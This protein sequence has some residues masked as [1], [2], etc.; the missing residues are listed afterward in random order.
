M[1]AT[2]QQTY[3]RTLQDARRV[4]EAFQ[5]RTR[6]ID[7]KL[8][9]ERIA[10]LA[11]GELPEGPEGR[12]SGAYL[13][14]IMEVA[15]DAPDV[16][17][18]D[19]RAFAKEFVSRPAAYSRTKAGLAAIQ[20]EAWLIEHGGTLYTKFVETVLDSGDSKF[21]TIFEGLLSDQDK[22]KLRTG[23]G[24]FVKI[25]PIA[26]AGAINYDS[27]ELLEFSM[28]DCTAVGKIEKDVLPKSVNDPAQPG[29]PPETRPTFESLHPRTRDDY[30]RVFEQDGISRAVAAYVLGSARVH[31]AIVEGGQLVLTDRND[32]R[33]FSETGDTWLPD[34][35]S[36]EDH[37]PAEDVIEDDVD[38]SRP[39]LCECNARTGAMR[40]FCGT[41]S[42]F[43]SP[44]LTEGETRSATIVTAR[45]S[46][47]VLDRP[48]SEARAIVQE[49]SAHYPDSPAE[50][51]TYIEAALAEYAAEHG[52][53]CVNEDEVLR[54]AFDPERP[55][56]ADR[57]Y[58]VRVITTRRLSEALGQ[59]G[60]DAQALAQVATD[61]M[62]KRAPGKAHGAYFDNRFGQGGTLFVKFYNAPSDAGDV[63]KLNSKPNFTLSIGPFDTDGRALS[64]K[65]KAV[66]LTG[67]PRSL[68]W[69]GKTAP[70]DA[71]ARYIE[72]FIEKLDLDAPVVEADDDE[73]KSKEV[74]D[75][76]KGSTPPA[77]QD[78]EGDGEAPPEGDGQAVPFEPPEPTD[79]TDEPEYYRDDLQSYYDMQVVQGRS[80]PEALAALK[81]KFEITKPITI[82]PTGEVRVDGVT[83]NPKPPRPG[84]PPPPPPPGTVPPPGAEPEEEEP[85]SQIGSENSPPKEEES[86]DEARK[87]EARDLAIVA[88]I[89]VVL[90][91]LDRVQA[92]WAKLEDEVKTADDAEIATF[93]ALKKRLG[94]TNYLEVPDSDRAEV[95]ARRAAVD[96]L[97]AKRDAFW[98]QRADSLVA[99]FEVLQASASD[100]LYNGKYSTIYSA[101]SMPGHRVGEAQRRVDTDEI[102]KELRSLHLRPESR[103]YYDT[104]VRNRK[105]VE[106]GTLAPGA[107]IAVP[108]PPSGMDAGYYTITSKTP[109]GTQVKL[110]N[111]ETGEEIQ[112][113]AKITV[114][115]LSA[116]EA[117]RGMVIHKRH[118]DATKDE[119][120]EEGVIVV[121]FEMDHSLPLLEAIDRLAKLRERSAA[122]RSKLG[123]QHD[124]LE[125][126]TLH[127]RFHRLV[128]MRPSEIRQH[129]QSRALRETLNVTRKS[130]VESIQLGR[131]AVE[132]ALRLKGTPIEEWTP[133][134]WEW[135]ERIVKFIERTRRNAAPVVDEAGKPTRKVLTLRTWGHDPL[136][137]ARMSIEEFETLRSYDP[138]LAIRMIDATST[139]GP[140]ALVEGVAEKSA[141]PF[142]TLK[143][144]RKPLT[145]E[146]RSAC[147]RAKAVWLMDKPTPAVWRSEVD[148]KTYYVTNSPRLYNV[149]PTLEGAIGRFHQCIKSTN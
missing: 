16:N 79:R 114:L 25:E 97:R 81:K 80:E 27:G 21:L 4:A 51:D 48:L 73:E 40:S 100:P 53:A 146:E 111:S 54:V 117:K 132:H 113:P 95:D 23:T 130:K 77:D 106:V 64:P 123:E 83:D 66:M 5:A 67:Y 90:D 22:D 38:E 89:R 44:V 127:G 46:A 6:G 63:A 126:A 70:P 125:R 19:A 34:V 12:H 35:D 122:R 13:S 136:R 143:A 88:K 75:K 62:R 8:L 87:S 1:A 133:E 124:E 59:G 49:V 36:I 140:V 135:C 57:D 84:T 118:I 43:D 14:V 26:E 60:Y 137:E 112:V 41:W 71:M 45:E 142:K 65:L 91:K 105:E 69:R 33:W 92:G 42:A 15:A 94:V 139:L 3:R 134:M 99:E 58:D 101:Y 86:V 72:A 29:T 121:T 102:R 119:S 76:P 10:A 32:V 96:K 85:K 138:G 104:V 18:D 145:D 141:P 37:E 120:A 107:A 61:A 9:R 115:P 74:A 131:D 31:G 11:A 7:G 68:P 93:L 20:L 24:A 47:W 108:K 17:R 39:V 2:L 56:R 30:D 98:K 116:A 28:F 109:K 103:A 149:R 128:N 55:T 52:T 148:G 110:T 50:G 147:V 129:L 144:N 82:T 78:G